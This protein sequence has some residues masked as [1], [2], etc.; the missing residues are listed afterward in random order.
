MT[1]R[2]PTITVVAGTNGAGK[3]SIIGE[4]IHA[5][6]GA[7]YDPDKTARKLRTANPVLSQAEANSLAWTLG[8]QG[9][10]DALNRRTDYVFETTLGGESISVLLREAARQGFRVTVWYLGLAS[11]DEHIRRV[12]ARVE[13]GGHDIDET[14]IRER[15]ARSRENLVALMPHLYELKLFDNSETVDIGKGEAPRPRILLHV[16]QS[17]IVDLA[18][19]TTMPDWAKPLAMAALH[20]AGMAS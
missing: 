5:R 16:R 6:G 12:R 15:F 13:R 1:E 18:E 3:S 4:F 20:L 17:R 7:C 14:R 2:V 9:L 10:D 19:P 11:V 8:K